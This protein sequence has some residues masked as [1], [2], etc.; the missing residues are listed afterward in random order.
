M[1]SLAKEPN[2]L[3]QSSTCGV[4]VFLKSPIN[5]AQI[6]YKFTTDSSRGKS[7]HSRGWVAPDWHMKTLQW[8]WRRVVMNSRRSEISDTL[9]NG[10]NTQKNQHV[11]EVSKLIRE[12]ARTPA[13]P[14]P[15][16][17]SRHGVFVNVFE[18]GIWK[19]VWGR[20]GA[21]SHF[22]SLWQSACVQKSPF[23]STFLPSPSMRSSFTWNGILAPSR[24]RDFNAV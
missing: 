2:H 5:P 7:L 20:G 9:N 1:E 8:R 12:S 6:K 24:E 21:S 18:R 13:S 10:T 14:R 3:S 17:K 4:K 22:S 16:P 19:K 23:Q 11:E 15:S